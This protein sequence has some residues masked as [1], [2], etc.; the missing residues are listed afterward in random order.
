MSAEH[1]VLERQNQSLEAEDERVH[2][3]ERIHDMESEAMEK[4]GIF[5]DDGV[6][7]V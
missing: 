4:T 7:I 2:K 6:V 1:Q 3:R 5:V